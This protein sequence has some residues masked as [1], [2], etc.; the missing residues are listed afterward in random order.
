MA[1]LEGSGKRMYGGLPVV[2][3][4]LFFTTGRVGPSSSATLPYL[5]PNCLPLVLSLLHVWKLLV[6]FLV[7]LLHFYHLTEALDM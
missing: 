4:L 3:K 5:P 2:M 6:G 7:G 1:S